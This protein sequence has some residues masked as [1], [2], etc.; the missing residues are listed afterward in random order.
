VDFSSGKPDP[1]VLALALAAETERLKYM[2][3]HRP[4][5]MAPTLFV[6]QVNTFSTLAPDR[7][8]LN[9]VAGHSPGEQ[10]TYGDALAHDER[11][12]RMQEYLSV[13]Q[14]LWSEDGPVDFEGR[15]Y[16][17]ERGRV[18]TPFVSDGRRRPEIYLGGGSDNARANDD[19]IKMVRFLFLA[20][21]ELS[22]SNLSRGRPAEAPVSTLYIRH[23]DITTLNYY[24]L[25]EKSS[26]C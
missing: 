21:H 6:Q 17:I 8:T 18:K 4:G 24:F 20:H 3:A 14:R 10:A 2:V 23:V 7:I 15:H 11:Y 19:D 22:L 12:A 13:C 5:L 16:R 26:L 9:M 1:M 25:A